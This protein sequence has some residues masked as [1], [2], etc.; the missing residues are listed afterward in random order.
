MKVIKQSSNPGRRKSNNDSELRR[1]CS[2]TLF[3]L[4]CTKKKYN[5]K[6]SFEFSLRVH[7]TG[8]GTTND[9]NTARRFF[10]NLEKTAEITG[11]DITLLNRIK[12]LLTAINCGQTIDADQ[13]ETYALKTAEL[14]KK[15]L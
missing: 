6:L 4:V 13:F 15:T 14:Y 2:L 10:Q 9:G 11:L 1:G 3:S 8:K 12:N 7:S 5:L